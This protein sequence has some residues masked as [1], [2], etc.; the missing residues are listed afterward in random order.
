MKIRLY[1]FNT[2]FL[3]GLALALLLAITSA[4]TSSETKKKGYSKKDQASLRLYLEVNPAG[5]DR[6]GM[7]TVGRTAPFQLNVEKKAFLTE[8]NIEHA[9]VVDTFGGFSISIRYDKEGSWL[10]EQYSTAN[11]GKRIAIVAEFGQVRWLAAPVIQQRLGDGLLVFAPDAT[12]E[13]SERIVSGLNRI[14]KLIKSGS[15]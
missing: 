9:S 14:A 11:K 13:E 8:H 5:S 10:L 1:R 7:I 2:Y 12:R 6:S 4:C 3:A 15:L